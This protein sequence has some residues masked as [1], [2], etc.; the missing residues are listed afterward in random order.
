GA[1]CAPHP[2]RKTSP[3]IHQKRISKVCLIHP[4]YTTYT[5]LSVP[6]F[7]GLM[8]RPDHPPQSSQSPRL[9]PLVRLFVFGQQRVEDTYTHSESEDAAPPHSPLHRKSRPIP[10]PPSC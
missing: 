2:T 9:A 7:R 4:Q 6:W 8:A 10:Q 3:I 5:F 1:D